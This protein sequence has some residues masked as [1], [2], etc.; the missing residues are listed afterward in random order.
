MCRIA[1]YQLN[2]LE[3]LL[4][5][6]DEKAPISGKAALRARLWSA[7]NRIVVNKGIKGG[8]TRIKKIRRMR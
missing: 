1:N 4:E 2:K 3:D 6:I 7:A 5:D 8:N